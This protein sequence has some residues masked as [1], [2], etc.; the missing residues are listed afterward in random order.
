MADAKSPHPALDEHLKTM[1][2]ALAAQWEMSL[3]CRCGVC[4][5]TRHAYVKSI[6]HERPSLERYKVSEVTERFRCSNC[7]S[8]YLT[9]WL[10]D[11]M[12]GTSCPGVWPPTWGVVVTDRRNRAR[13]K[14]L[15]GGTTD[16]PDEYAPQ[17]AK[18][19]F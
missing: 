18:M 16:V 12:R 3:H 4:R 6:L 1:P 19:L 11:D 13:A 15:P 17:Y 2:M 10:S 8:P 9:V 14:G 5:H 7:A